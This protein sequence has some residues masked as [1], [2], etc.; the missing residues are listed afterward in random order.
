MVQMKRWLL[1]AGVAA[2]SGSAMAQVTGP[3]PLSWK[4]QQSTSVVPGVMSA[5]GDTLFAA[6]GRRVYALDKSTGNQVWRYPVADPIQG[7]FNRGALLMG[8]LVIAA[9]DNRTVYA[10]DAATGKSAWEYN[11]EGGLAGNPVIAGDL[12]ILPMGD[13][14]LIALKASDGTP[15]WAK[16]LAIT[17][18]MYGQIAAEGNDVYV[19]TGSFELMAI[20]TTRGTQK[21]KVQFTQLSPDVTPVVFE[22]LVYVISG[23]Y[24]L[25]MARQNGGQRVRITVGEQAVFAPAVTPNTISVVTEAGTVKTFSKQ[26][27]Q[28]HKPVDLESVAVN[29]PSIVG[30]KIAV[31]TTNGSMQLI[32]PAD[33]SVLWNYILRPATKPAADASGKTPPNLMTAAHPARIM[34]DTLLLPGRDGQILAFDAKTGVDLT[35]PKVKFVFPANGY[36][37]S[38]RTSVGAGEQAPFFLWDIE[39]LGTGVRMDTV[40]VEIDGQVMKHVLTRDGQL[41]VIINGSDNPGLRDGAKTLTVSAADWLG[42]IAKAQF[43]VSIDNTLP[44]LKSASGGSGGGGGGAVGGA[45][46]GRNGTGT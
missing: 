32:E 21:W 40:K 43:K 16:P 33:G 28:L 24:V 45:G 19:S 12:V 3:V 4:W 1:A 37:M 13:D 5:M 17:N 46:G 15:A 7:N 27:R 14:T 34:G 26:G 2:L 36:E 39:D 11:M 29:A 30:G 8:N 23:D 6:V 18:G 22:D 44:A 10:L 20:D 42:N 9:A 25:G 31:N 38:G 41:A 35:A